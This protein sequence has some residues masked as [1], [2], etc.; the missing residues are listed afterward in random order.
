M[1][2]LILAAGRGSR[3]GDL[4]ANNP[5]CM[6]KVFGK[7]L[8]EHQIESLTQAGIENIAIV[9][10]YHSEALNHPK[11]IKHYHNQDWASTNMVK[12]LLCASD[13]LLDEACII[14]YSDIFYQASCITN[15]TQDNSEL[16]I[17]YDVNYRALW[18]LRYQEP[19]NDLETFKIDE[20]SYLTSI[21]SRATSFSDM[22]GQY[23]GILKITPSAWLKILNFLNTA[24]EI[25][26]AKLDMTS[27]LMK[28]IQDDIMR[29]KAIPYYGVWG[30]VDHK[31]DIEC[32]E[33]NLAFA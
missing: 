18:E 28:I 12:S 10:G 4:T 15:L 7:P 32:Y 3:L 2:G 22:M 26:L 16:S 1:K 33:N 14:S 19:L 25:D 8:L 31:S 29:I 9:T 13:W 21:G 23:M 5:K 17:S 24:E 30:E 27:L 6:V 20:N 11:L